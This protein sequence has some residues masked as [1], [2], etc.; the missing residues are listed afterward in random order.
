MGVK[1]NASAI[2]SNLVPTQCK[3]SCFVISKSTVKMYAVRVSMY[4]ASPDL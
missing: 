2:V 3:E 4:H 1:E